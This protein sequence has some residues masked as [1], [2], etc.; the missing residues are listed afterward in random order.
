MKSLVVVLAL[1]LPGA[2]ASANP[3]PTTSLD[4]AM[5]DSV[6]SIHVDLSSET[7]SGPFTYHGIT[8]SS[9]AVTGVASLTNSPDEKVLHFLLQ[10]ADGN[11]FGTLDV[12]TS[13]NDSNGTL[14]LSKSSFPF[15]VGCGLQ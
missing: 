5:G 15:H 10:T 6:L 14:R 11:A 8:P 12:D 3:A 9:P 1:A 13:S 7:L 4:C 2:F